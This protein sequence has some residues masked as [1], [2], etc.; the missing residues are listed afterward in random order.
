MNLKALQDKFQ[1]A[2]LSGDDGILAQIPDSPH[3]KKAVL[4]GV[5]QYGYMARLVEVIGNDHE[6][7]HTYLGDEE[8]DAM[9]RAYLAAFPS[10]NPNARWVSQRLPAFLKA[11]APYK[12]H[13]VVGD[14]ALLE[15]SLNDAFD[16]KE[17][18]VLSLGNLGQ[19]PPEQ[20]ENLVFE[21]HPAVARI[22][23]STNA[24]PIWSALKAEEEPPA[25]EALSEPARIVVWRKG[26]AS[27]FRELA[28]EEAMMWDEAGKGVRFGVLCEMVATFDDP[29][30]AP[31][32][33]AQ[34]LQGWIAS[35]MLSGAS[36]KA[37]KRRKA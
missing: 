15:K 13:A 4:L 7:L 9:A 33:A 31:V 28:R 30:T 32:R 16:A 3:E 34:Y 14:L 11:T 12:S 18:P 36:I 17:G 26:T 5:Y 29:D 23:L 19:V 25:A 35:E 24:S 6:F 21:A 27:L 8:F 22:D 1:Q 2:I 10:R 20:W 37:R